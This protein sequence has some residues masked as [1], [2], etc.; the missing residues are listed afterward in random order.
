M[1]EKIT[2][3]KQKIKP[4]QI[5]PVLS[6][7]DVKMQLEELHQKFV[8]VTIDKPSSNSS[9]ICRKYYISKLLAEVYPNKNKNLTSTYSQTQKSREEIIKTNIKYCKK[10]DLNITEQ[11]KTLPIMYWLPKMHKTT[12]VQD[13]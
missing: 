12:S 10:F 5:K 6:D 3:L 11:D 13:S 9:F 7:P 2:E 4:K 1:K 8:I